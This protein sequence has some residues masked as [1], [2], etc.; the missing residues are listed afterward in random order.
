MKQGKVR[1]IGLSNETPYGV[2]EFISVAERRGYTKISSVQNPYCLIGRMAENGLDEMLFKLDITFLGYSP[3]AFGLLTGKYDRGLM[4]NAGTP[5]NSRLALYE[6]V[7]KQRWGK[8]YSLEVAIIYNKLARDV[9]LTP[10][11]MA[12]AFCYRK[13]LLGSTI[14]GVTSLGQLKENIK[15]FSIQLG[16]ELLTRIDEIRYIKRDPV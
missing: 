9:G 6:S 15:A 4:S 14:I 16:S 5:R 2:H 7:R 11:E 1:A 13:K 10:A 12:L 8:S 3:L